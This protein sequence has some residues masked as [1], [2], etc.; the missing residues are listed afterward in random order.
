[1]SL[2]SIF[3]D[4]SGLTSELR[5]HRLVMT[6]I[7]EALER[8]SPP[9]KEP[10]KTAPGAS[11]LPD[12][13][14]GFFLAESPEEHQER[15]DTEAALA[16]SLGVAPWSPAFQKAILEFRSDLMRTRIGT[17]AEGNK[18]ENPGCTRDEADTIIKDAFATAQA[19]S[20]QR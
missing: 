1:V 6:R 14:N 2:I 18:V 5:E 19:R 17:D 12:S 3:A 15:T 20:N 10:T 4:L 13:P 16:I 9:L 7:A 11:D 8:V